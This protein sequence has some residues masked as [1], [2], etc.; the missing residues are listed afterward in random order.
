MEGK[1]EK[2]LSG[3]I[4]ISERTDEEATQ[5]SDLSDVLLS[6]SS[7]THHQ[8]YVL[9]VQSER[10]RR[11]GWLELTSSCPRWLL[12]CRQLDQLISRNH[13]HSANK[14][15]AQ[16]RIQTQK[17]LFIRLQSFFFS[18]PD[19]TEAGSVVIA[20]PESNREARYKKESRAMHSCVYKTHGFG[21]AR[22]GGVLQLLL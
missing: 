7:V 3:G 22:E 2:S 17:S 16:T 18:F 13:N 4:R 20:S 9:V 1:K 19:E 21:G 5:T 8:S 6:Q 11:G 12:A 14:K 10:N 15:I